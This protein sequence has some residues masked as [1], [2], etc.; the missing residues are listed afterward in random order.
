MLSVYQAPVVIQTVE[1]NIAGGATLSVFPTVESRILEDYETR[2]AFKFVAK[3][4]KVNRYRS[5][6]DFFFCEL[7]PEWRRPCVAFYEDG[8]QL[9]DILSDNQ[10]KL[11]ERAMWVALDDAVKL[12]GTLN[13]CSWT[14]FRSVFLKNF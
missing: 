5:V 10:I 8:P 11:Y 13:Q 4:K 1:L 3:T 2:K 6:M 7:F 9:V 14:K 12:M